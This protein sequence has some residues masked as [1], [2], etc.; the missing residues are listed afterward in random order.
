MFQLE[1]KIHQKEQ[2]KFANEL[3]WQNQG[4]FSL[5]VSWSNEIALSHKL[6]KHRY[7]FIKWLKGSLEFYDR[8]FYQQRLAKSEVA[9]EKPEGSGCQDEPDLSSQPF[10]QE[11]PFPSTTKNTI[12][13]ISSKPLYEIV[14]ILI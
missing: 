12:H 13:A 11:K 7:G 14:L 6:L 3:V 9:F 4:I 10:F 1:H 5:Y 8:R 2:K